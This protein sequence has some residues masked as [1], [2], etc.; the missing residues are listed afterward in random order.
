LGSNPL[1]ILLFKDGLVRFAT[2][3][4]EKVN[5]SNKLQSFIHFTNFAI[6]KE[7]PSYI[8]G[9]D[10]VKSTSHKRSIL[11]FFSELEGI[12]INVKRIWAEIEDLV[13][14]TMISIQPILKQNYVLSQSNDPYN[15][16]CFEILGF[17][18]I[19]D[20]RLKPILLEVNHSPS[21]QTDS[22]IDLKIKNRLIEDTIR[23][24]NINSNSKSELRELALS[25]GEGGTKH[26]NRYDTIIRQER[27]RTCIKRRD[28][29][30]RNNL[31]GF[32]FI[33][34]C[35]KSDSN[36]NPRYERLL[37]QVDMA[38]KNTP[39]CTIGS[40]IMPKIRDQKKKNT[41]VLPENPT[42]DGKIL[43]GLS[44][45]KVQVLDNLLLRNGD[46]NLITPIKKNSV[47]G[48]CTPS[49]GIFSSASKI[50]KF[51]NLPRIQLNEES[52]RKSSERPVFIGMKINGHK[53]GENNRKKL[54]K[55]VLIPELNK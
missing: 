11:D 26:R 47:N 8:P 23:L 16:M 52:N 33:Y 39:W 34:P 35:Q 24:L 22:S 27:K 43:T 48:L 2:E 31:G 45:S 38:Y 9:E 30:I 10:D 46:K 42:L 41:V 5:E 17:D 25:Q 51:G 50:I 29:F 49:I 55:S 53:G 4:Y 37:K 3:H 6:N 12:G 21:F 36:L 54:S 32:N 18:V 28:E 7:N 44:M 14:K 1:R 19:L 20:N 15:Q 13:V 40:S